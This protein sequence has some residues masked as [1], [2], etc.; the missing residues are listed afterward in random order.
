MSYRG[1]SS[2]VADHCMVHR[3]Y[4]STVAGVRGVTEAP[5]ISQTKRI[6]EFAFVEVEVV[7]FQWED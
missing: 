3:E 2:H 4:G 6:S 1:I 5:P 7:V